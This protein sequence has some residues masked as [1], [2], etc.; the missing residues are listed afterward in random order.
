[1]PSVFTWRSLVVDQGLD[2]N[3][4]VELM[5]GLVDSA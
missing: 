3:Q 5:T 2:P 4:A 1:L